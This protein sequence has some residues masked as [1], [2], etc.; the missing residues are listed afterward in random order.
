MTSSRCCVSLLLAT[1]LSAQGWSLDESTPVGLGSVVFDAAHH[2]AVGF[3]G[4]PAK[5]WSFDG[6]A[7]R[8]HNPEDLVGYLVE[9][10]AFDAVRGQCVVTVNSG[11][12]LRT[13]VSA[14]AGW[15][16]AQQGGLVPAVNAAAAFDPNRG[17]VIAFGGWDRTS[18][19]EVDSMLAWNGNFWSLLQ[20][21][22]KPSPRTEAGLALDP[23]RGRVVLFGGSVGPSYLGDTWEWD[24]A[25]W[26]QRFPAVSP[27]ARAGNLAFDPVAQEIVLLGGYQAGVRLDVW[28]WNGTQWQ[29]R[30][31]LPGPSAAAGW[32]DGSRLL[33]TGGPQ[34]TDVL[35]ANGSSWT[36]V[37]TDQKPSASS[38]G[39]FAYDAVRDEVL[40]AGGPSGV[41]TW[42][43]NGSWQLRSAQGPGLRYGSAM[44]PIGSGMVLFGGSQSPWGA[45]GDTWR[46]NGTSWTMTFPAT[47]PTARAGHAMANVGNHV[48]L[49]GGTAGSPLLDETW[50]YDGITWTQLQPANVPAARHSAGLAYDP[51]RQRA[52]LY[53]GQGR[54]VQFT[55]L[56]EW[57]G[58][59]W[60]QRYPTSQPA[61]DRWA[62]AY[63]SVRA[64]VVL[65]TADRVWSWD[66]VDWAADPATAYGDQLTGMVAFHAGRQR[67]VAFGERGV[68]GVYG[69]TPASVELSPQ[70]CGN[71]PDLRL[72][73][74]PMVGTTSQV[75]VEAAP[76]TLAIVAYGLQPGLVNWAP[77]CDQQIAIGATFAGVL[78]GR[79]ALSIPF[80]VPAA[81]GFRGVEVMA[82]AVVLDGGPV[83]GASLSGALRLA[84]GD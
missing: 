51:Q 8:R 18:Y 68:L 84:I 70:A 42:A 49:F 35:R 9:S 46:W 4:L 72:F 67:L 82:Q 45:I 75:R 44:A 33:I 83:F 55:D 19:Q 21:A 3:G 71:S 37:F 11:I 58:V 27:P 78:D 69:P 31:N 80:V 6:T 73:G 59:D 41:D 15:Q 24:G 52:V 5:T 16:L 65:P 66:G 61:T 48:L 76:N 77:G 2:R 63:D 7:W 22:V 74:R 23:V 29:A 25:A 38:S 47:Q 39:A 50:I 36:P 60:L 54:A 1:A 53:G 30:G 81:L 28:G 43:W 10:A 40:L 12:S 13:Y 14:G 17:T 79:G 62:L 64:K 32:S 26:S 56:W 57:D 20:P 34:G